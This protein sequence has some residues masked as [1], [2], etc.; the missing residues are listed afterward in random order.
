MRFRSIMALLAALCLFLAACGGDDDDTNAADD[1]KEQA[2][3]QDDGEATDAD[4]D[5]EA[6]ADVDDPDAA[7]IPDD[8]DLGE[9]G[10]LA[11]IFAGFE[12]EGMNLF[13]G[14]GMSDMAEGLS[15]AAGNAPSE[16]SDQIATMATY[17]G[18]V[19]EA[20]DGA[21]IDLSDPANVDP[22][23]MEAMTEA[24]S[25]LE[26]AEFTAASEEFSQWAEANCSEIA[27]TNPF[28]TP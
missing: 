2:D 20:L 7:D 4:G 6:S 16:I 12:T 28:G 22:A 5:D 10:F 14:D 24:M 9:C 23:A 18:D 1:G 11:D 27:G 21:D 26:D 19:A 17:F 25:Q 13:S 8:L 15:N 3:N